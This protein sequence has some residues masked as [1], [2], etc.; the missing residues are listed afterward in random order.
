MAAT[1]SPATRIDYTGPKG[2]DTRT[3][4]RDIDQVADDFQAIGFTAQMLNGSTSV[5][6]KGRGRNHEK[7][8]LN[9][10]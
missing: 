8:V 3:V 9:R 10:A 7:V 4:D 5:L 1:A 2:V 6:A